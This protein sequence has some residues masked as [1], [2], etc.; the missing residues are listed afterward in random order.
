[1]YSSIYKVNKLLFLER[2]RHAYMDPGNLHTE[3]HHLLI[4]EAGIYF[5]HDA[6]CDI[7]SQHLQLPTFSVWVNDVFSK[8]DIV[9]RPF[10]P[11]AV[12]T[13]HFM[14]EDSL[15]T[16]FRQQPGY[17]LE[18]R[19]CNLFH[20]PPGLHKVPMPNSKKVLSLHINI[21]PAEVP[22]LIARYPVLQ[23]MAQPAHFT[24]PVNTLP[25]HINPVCELLIKQI[26]ICTYTGIRAKKFLYR[27]C[28]DLLLNIAQQQAAANQLLLF[29]T[30]IKGSAYH[31]LFDYLETHPH[32]QHTIAALAYI[33]E[34]PPEEL[35]HGFLQ[36]FAVSVEDFTHM[37]KMMFIY[38]R[39][40]SKAFPLTLIAKT[41]GYEEVNLMM[42]AVEKFYENS[43]S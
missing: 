30:I 7:L 4:P 19:E 33:F 41:A 1:M 21:H 3:L 36:L 8:K 10:T 39:I 25:Y 43:F 23:F 42:D 9:L 28:L 16:Q 24:G 37:S 15:R 35:A 29:S 38:N 12:H 14:F 6:D 17:L 26:L 32:K 2:T 40:Q 34:I 5:R 20:L 13:L 18:E 11:V 22:L 31:Q 27:C